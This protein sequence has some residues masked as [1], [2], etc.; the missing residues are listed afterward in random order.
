VTT[1]RAVK[2]GGVTPGDRVAISGIGGLD[3]LAQR[4][5]QILGG[6]TITIDVT[7]EKL[8]LAKQ[9]GAAQVVNAA[10]TDPVTAIEALAGKAHFR[11]GLSAGPVP[12]TCSVV[13]SEP[14]SGGWLPSWP[15]TLGRRRWRSRLGR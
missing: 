6:E 2:V 13:P 10:I 5:P 8:A 7:E 11:P 9:L 12:S 15:V 4:Y 14:R 3:H 1:Y